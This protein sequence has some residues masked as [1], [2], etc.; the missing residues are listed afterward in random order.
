[1]GSFCPMC[2]GEIGKDAIFCPFCGGSI[3]DRKDAP[4]S[5]AHVVQETIPKQQIQPAPTQIQ[6]PPTQKQYTEEIYADFGS[7]FVAFIIDSLIV[8]MIQS[9]ILLIFGIAPFNLFGNL[10]LST[11][12]SFVIGF[13]YF[14]MLESGNNGQTIGKAVL[15]LRTVDQDSLKPTD[16]G[17]YLINNLSRSSGFFILDFILVI[18]A[19]SGKIDKRL[20]IL[21]NFS[22]TVVIKL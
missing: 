9:I 20:R 10:F 16:M 13:F 11:I 19:N 7:R 1:M 22:K 2:G 5:P 6:P 15:H 8:Y 4:V 12:A 21:Q 17:N 18:I 14:W 3:A